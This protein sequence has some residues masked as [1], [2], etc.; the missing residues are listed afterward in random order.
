M[1]AN[2]IEFA[3]FTHTSNLGLFHEAFFISLRLSLRDCK[4]AIYVCQTPFTLSRN[5]FLFYKE[6]YIGWETPFR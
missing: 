4:V 3:K 2:K 5:H 6:V 1:K